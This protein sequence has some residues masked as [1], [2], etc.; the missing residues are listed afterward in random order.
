MISEP[1]FGKTIGFY[2]FQKLAH[3]KNAHNLNYAVLMATKHA[4][5]CTQYFMPSSEQRY[6]HIHILHFLVIKHVIIN[7]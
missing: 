3:F 7:Y 4:I 5:F 6:I 2:F 1:I